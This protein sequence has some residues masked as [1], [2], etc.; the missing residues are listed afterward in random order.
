MSGTI[1]HLSASGSDQSLNVIVADTTMSTEPMM[2]EKSKKQ[3]AA[4]KIK[5]KNYQEE[6]AP[7][8]EGLTT[9]A[10]CCILAFVSLILYLCFK[11]PFDFFTWHPLLLSL[12]WMFLM[13]E[14]ILALS[15]E[16]ILR[17]KFK[18]SGSLKIFLH[19][20]SLTAAAILI[21]IGFLVITIN[22]NRLNKYHY[23]SWHGLLGLIAVITYIPPCI[24]GVATLYGKDLKAYLNPKIVKLVHVVTG[25]LCFACG[26]ISLI[27]SVYTKW[28]ARRTNSNLFVFLLGLVITIFPVIWVVQRPLIKSVTNISKMFSKQDKD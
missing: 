22:K 1:A 21:L 28:F 26:G 5:H 6:S 24:N 13:S 14:G 20:T 7:V 11:E 4:G 3:G 12:G 8:K 19:W 17:K 27:L 15:K 23:T 16:S 2:G 25:T 18:I 10:H 9:V